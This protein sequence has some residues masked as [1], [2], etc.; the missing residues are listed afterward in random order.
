MKIAS[1]TS[2][3][4]P[5]PGR[6]AAKTRATALHAQDA[7]AARAAG[8]RY[9]TDAE[10][11]LARVTAGTSVV[12]RDA[13]GR[14]VDEATERR[15]KALAIPPAWTHVWI[16]RDARAHVQATGRDARGRKQYR[17]HARWSAVR[18]EAK[19]DRLRAF[20][21][22]LPA[23]RRRV[24][25]DLHARPLSQPWVLATVMRLL[26]CS[27]IRIGH[28]EYRRAN[29]SYGLTTL[30]N[31]HADVQGRVLTLHFRAKSGVDQV[32]RVSDV[33]LARRVGQCK[34]LPGRALFQFVD[35]DGH[36]HPITAG[37]INQYLHDATGAPFT[38]KDFRTWAGTLEAAR[39]L[40]AAERREPESAR[41]RKRELDRALDEVAAKLGNTR[42]VCRKC[43]VHPAILEHYFEGRTLSSSRIRP[44]AVAGLDADERAL[45]GLLEYS[46][47]W[48]S[49][50]VS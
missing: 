42:A 2:N 21:R 13:H 49:R 25:A 31:R 12:Y 41:A 39:A 33:S 43:Y 40:D 29:G 37:D 8:L 35:A 46:T 10:P 19:Y 45:L 4:S 6:S 26:E 32:I 15:I 11:G 14:R 9:A 20:A 36:R 24:A 3:L 38:A 47:D 22:A 27:V 7:A 1:R 34:R 44:S 16:A 17:Y 50:A 28:E 5:A 48:T 18:S 23:V 30:L